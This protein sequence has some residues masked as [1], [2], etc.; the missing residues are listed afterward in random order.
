MRINPPSIAIM[1][2]IKSDVVKNSLFF[3]PVMRKGNARN[4]QFSNIPEI[5]N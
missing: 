3:K 2:N 1:I 5:I 4:E